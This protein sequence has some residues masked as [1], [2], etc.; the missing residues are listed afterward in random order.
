M[1]ITLVLGEMITS[2][3]PRQIKYFDQINGILV[4]KA[5]KKII[6]TP[7]GSE[8]IVHIVI[9]LLMY[10]FKHCL[11]YVAQLCL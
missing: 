9:Q 1:E 3:Q 11:I 2:S 8:N 6:L 5:F 7:K 10:T 4:N